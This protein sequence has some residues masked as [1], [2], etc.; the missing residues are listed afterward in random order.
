LERL[1][2]EWRSDHPTASVAV[3]RPTIALA[4]ERTGWMAWSLWG[5]GGVQTEDVGPPAQFVHLD[6]LAAAVDLARRRGL[7]GVYN[8]A[9]DGWIAAE[10]MKALAGPRARIRLPEPLAS[11]LA[12]ARFRLGLTPTPPAVLPYTVHPWVVANDRLRA[13]GW[14]PANSNEETFVS[15]NRPGPLESLSSRRRQELTL[16]AVALAIVGLVAG[17]VYG[18]VRLRRR[19]RRR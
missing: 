13:E 16:G 2:G 17:S 11:R 4:E 3:L 10:E 12:R 1:A 19:A 5:S 8:V 14:E 9:P 18:I 7:D 6:D 15:A